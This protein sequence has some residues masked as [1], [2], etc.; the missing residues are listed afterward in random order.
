[1][2]LLFEKQQTL[3]AGKSAEQFFKRG[4]QE[5]IGEKESLSKNC[6]VLYQATPDPVTR[7]RYLTLTYPSQVRRLGLA[8]Y[9]CHYSTALKP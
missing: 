2:Y 1:M 4:C 8:V 3:K 9:F 6:I 5:S 7:S